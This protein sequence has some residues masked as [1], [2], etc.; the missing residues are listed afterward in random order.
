MNV[1]SFTLIDSHIGQIAIVWLEK[2]SELSILRIV[3]PIEGINTK[4]LVYRFFE[5]KKKKQEE[6]FKIVQ[7]YGLRFPHP[8]VYDIYE[9]VKLILI[10]YPIKYPMEH[11]GMD[12][13]S[14]FKIDV[15]RSTWKIPNGKAISYG[16]LAEGVG[17]PRGARAVGRLL[18]GNPFPLVIPCH[19]VVGVNGDINGFSAGVKL[20]KMLLHIEGIRFD[21]N[22]RVKSVYLMN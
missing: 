6:S 9:S 12:N 15:L 22:G 18:A 13:F 21:H 2:K 11:L 20:K 14:K 17:V 5:E 3:L 4:V 10:G 8:A 7:V 1:I 19:R 16:K